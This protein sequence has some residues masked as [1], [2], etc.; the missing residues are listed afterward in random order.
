M[1]THLQKKIGHIQ[2]YSQRKILLRRLYEIYIFNHFF[3]HNLIRE[4]VNLN[5]FFSNNFD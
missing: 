5:I 4:S 1:D 2:G 3:L